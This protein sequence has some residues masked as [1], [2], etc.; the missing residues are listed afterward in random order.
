MS[1]GPFG[2]LMM[3]NLSAGVTYSEAALGNTPQMRTLM[4]Y[5]YSKRFHLVCYLCP[6]FPPPSPPPQTPTICMPCFC[7]PIMP[8]CL[9]LYASCVNKTCFHHLVFTMK[10]QNDFFW[11]V[12]M[13]LFVKITYIHY[14]SIE[15]TV[16]M[17]VNKYLF[18]WLHAVNHITFVIFTSLFQCR[19]S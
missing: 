1:L 9:A 5:S 6:G 13:Q 3:K 7:V 17:L 16:A 2:L 19:V 18:A 14:T 4:S 15:Y 10:Y 12:H 11:L 8:L